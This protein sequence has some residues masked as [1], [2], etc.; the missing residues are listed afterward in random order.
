MMAW[1]AYSGIGCGDLAV[2]Q[3]KQ[4]EQKFF[5]MLESYL[6]PF[7]EKNHGNDCVFIQDIAP[8]HTSNLAKA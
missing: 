5:N 3:G 7:T 6:L 1:G 4:D 8:C 2:L